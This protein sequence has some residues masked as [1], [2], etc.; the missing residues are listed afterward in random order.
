VERIEALFDRLGSMTDFRYSKYEGV[1][2]AKLLINDAGTFEQGHVL[3]G[4]LLG[5]SAGN[6]NGDASPDP[7]WRASEDFC[8]VFE[9]YTEAQTTSA[10]PAKKARQAYTHPNWIRSQLV[11]AESA[12]IVPILV[13]P[14]TEIE[15]G[16]VPH[17][18][19]V[20]HWSIDDLRRT[21]EEALALVR[22]LRRDY[23]GPGDIAWRAMA[24]ER[25]RAA[26]LSPREFV[27]ALKQR[28]VDLKVR[29]A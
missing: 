4:E 26:R 25:L 22:E 2:R 8:L 21:S 1:L 11:A 3:L 9:D 28:Q 12:E 18:D 19:G 24:A 7:W 20:I 23:P 14:C 10:I 27:E 15:Q 5:Y 6:R 17:M 13:S 16:A 29:G